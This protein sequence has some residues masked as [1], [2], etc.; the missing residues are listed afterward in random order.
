M[1]RKG[2]FVNTNL[3]E[4]WGELML[5]KNIDKTELRY[6]ARSVLRHVGLQ[7]LLYIYIFIGMNMLEM[8]QKFKHLLMLK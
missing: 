6:V 1:V 4:E 5:L 2:K 7:K 3:G 8:K